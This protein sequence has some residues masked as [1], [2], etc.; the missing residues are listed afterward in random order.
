M[1]DRYDVI[2]SYSIHYTKLYE[3]KFNNNGDQALANELRAIYN[4]AGVNIESAIQDY[5]KILEFHS[6]LIDTKKRLLEKDL[7]GLE[8][9][10]LGLEVIFV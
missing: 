6:N 9:E 10:K 7:P 1:F 8:K 2:T 5:T 4:Y 3:S